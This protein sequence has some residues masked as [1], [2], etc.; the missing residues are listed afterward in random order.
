M[1]GG[2]YNISSGLYSTVP[3]GYYNSAAS[4]YSFAAGYRAKANHPGSFVWADFQAADFSSTADNQFCIRAAGGVRLN[5]PDT[6]LYWGSG[7]RLWADQ[8]GSI[9]LGGNLA[10]GTQTRQKLNL[11]GSLYGIGVQAFNLYFRCNDG[12]N[13]G[14]IWYKGGVHNDA[15]TN[16]GGGTELMHLDSTGLSVNG[17][18]VS[19]SDRNAKENFA[20]VKP[21]EV[22]AKVAALPITSWNY[23]Q[24]AST[25]HLGP[26][27]QDFYAAFNIGPDD[28]HIA[29][30]DEGG[31]ALVA[32]QGLNQKV[33]S[34]NSALR[35]ELKRRD[36]E[37]AEL[38]AR[39][40]AL[41]K[42]V[43][44]LRSNGNQP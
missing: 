35:L 41:E 43:S 28:K 11:Y 2:E 5:N 44:H 29:V 26:M 10:F 9:E 24:D 4:N 40:S 34:E 15:Y 37:N 12:A 32:I 17:T 14:F 36:A 6:A 33:E 27:A 3:G 38:K 16:S 1:G 7:A 18:F 39:M 19:S 13:D 21:G 42:I 8:G 22:L 23:K 31:V 20:E 30:V 25:R